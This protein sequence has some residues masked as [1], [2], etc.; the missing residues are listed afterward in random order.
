MDTIDRGAARSIADMLQLS[1]GVVDALAVTAIC[2]LLVDVSL[3]DSGRSRKMSTP[4]TLAV[5]ELWKPHI[6]FAVENRARTLGIR[7]A[8]VMTAIA[9][10]RAVKP[11]PVEE[12]YLSLVNGEGLTR[13]MPA[14]T[15]RNY[16][17]DKKSNPKT[18]NERINFVDAILTAI[19][20][21]M[22][23]EK[24]TRVSANMEAQ[25]F[26]RKPQS[27]SIAKLEEI[28]PPVCLASIEEAVVA[29]RGG[30]N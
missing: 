29:A 1:H 5:L 18:G 25:E 14:L 20:L 17:I 24:M 6:A 28:F 12:F 2:K 10:A 16:I 22:R 27:A 26:F 30:G 4:Q 21:T 23:G 15:M 3:R 8:P 19:W 11:K 13:D 7:S 9:W